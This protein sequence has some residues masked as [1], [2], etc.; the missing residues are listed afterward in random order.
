MKL[1]VGSFIH[2]YY[3][4]FQYKNV[5]SNDIIMARLFISTLKEVAFE[6]FMKLPVGSIKKWDL[7]KLFLAHFFE[8]GTEIS[9]S[10]LLATNQKKEESI[11]TFMERFRSMA[12]RC[13][14]DMTQATLVKTCRHNLQ[15]TTLVLI[16]VANVALGS[17]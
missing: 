4:K 9:V 7:E 15:T 11:N 16:G 5:A 12:F 6:W 10:T 14:R 13:P 17:I 8:D 3:L 2:I 1:P